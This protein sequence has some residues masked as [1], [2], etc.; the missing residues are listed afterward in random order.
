MTTRTWRQGSRILW[1]PLPAALA[2]ATALLLALLFVGAEY[3]LDFLLGKGAFFEAGDAAQHVSGW[4]FFASDQWHFPLLFTERL[5]TPRGTSIAFTDSIPLAA[6]LFKPFV[7]WLP[8]HFHYIGMWHGIVYL[9]QAIGATFLIRALN[10]RH[11]LAQLAAVGFTLLWP[12]LLGRLGHTALMTHSL[13]LLALGFYFMGRRHVWRPD[14]TT[15]AFLLLSIAAL[16]VHPYLLA[17]CLT[18]YI[19]FLIDLGIAEGRWAWQALRL[20][21]VLAILVAVASMC[22]YFSATTSTATEGFGRYSMNLASPFCGGRI[23]TCV[24]DGNGSQG[25]GAN[26]FGAGVWLLLLI[27]TLQP[28]SRALSP[29]H[30]P[31]LAAALVL[32]TIYAISNVVYLGPQLL[33][34]Y[35]LPAFLAPVTGTFRASGR[36]FWPV[37]Y[38]VLFFAIASLLRKPSAWAGAAVV[39][40]LCLQ[41]LDLTPYRTTLATIV[42]RPQANDI[43]RWETIMTGVTQLDLYPGYSCADV[44][45]QFY[46]RMQQ[47]AGYYGARM[48]TAFVARPNADCHVLPGDP[49][50]RPQPHHLYVMPVHTLEK[51]PLAAPSVF[52]RLADRHACV[53]W[54]SALICRADGDA[55]TWAP[56]LPGARPVTLTHRAI[57]PA[58]KLPTLVGRLVDGTLVDRRSPARPDAA[59]PG[60]LSFGPY[61]TLPPGH[62]RWEITYVSAARA[63][64]NVATWDVFLNGGTRAQQRLVSGVLEGTLG[65][66]KTIEGFFNV[67]GANVTAEVRTFSVPTEDMALVSVGI[68]RLDAK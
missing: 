56:T 66:T 2:Y 53:L 32:L 23:L 43:L 26:F 41:W 57:W 40:A 44:E 35:P 7:D 22:G 11:L 64:A 45:P 19:A 30:F 14:N 3:P 29:R 31:A 68:D 48:N 61:A 52:Y 54:E 34:T 39:A 62:Y 21:T 63:A 37:G 58:D 24:T 25:E 36:F 27:V 51:D 16:L 49:T 10:V 50:G 5:N 4:W 38:A 28:R 60:V 12:P 46:A 47:V 20:S 67:E 17:M 6:L 15:F 1:R 13:L 18:I 65:V 33:L 59:G 42:T 9:T 55:E 8:S